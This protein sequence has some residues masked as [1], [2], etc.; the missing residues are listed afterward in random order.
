MVP[1]PGGVSAPTGPEPSA[2][3]LLSFFGLSPR[4][5][6]LERIASRYPVPVGVVRDRGAKI[7]Y[8]NMLAESK[9]HGLDHDTI[10]TRTPCP[11]SA[12]SPRTRPIFY[13]GMSTCKPRSTATRAS[14]SGRT[15]T[16][17]SCLTLD[18]HTALLLGT[19]VFLVARE[20][21]SD[22]RHTKEE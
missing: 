4:R 1:G 14:R 2:P 5:S 19:I 6:S 15:S 17:S 21:F 10:K 11:P 12:G 7:T 9:I 8:I 13:L 22:S 16:P 18:R 20:Q 3:R